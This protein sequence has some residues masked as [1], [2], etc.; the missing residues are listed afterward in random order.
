STPTPRRRRVCRAQ[1]DQNP[2]NPGTNN[3]AC[4]PPH[5]GPDSQPRLF[6][7]TFRRRNGIVDERIHLL[8]IFFFEPSK[9]IEVLDLGGNLSGKLCSVKTRNPGDPAA[10]FT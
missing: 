2:P 6:H 1:Y 5:P 9:R 10:S 3:S 4:A 8:D 7:C